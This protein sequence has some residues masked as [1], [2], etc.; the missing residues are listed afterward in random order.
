MS[1]NTALS[2]NQM[3]ARCQ[4]VRANK[5]LRRLPAWPNHRRR[6]IDS[7]IKELSMLDARKLG[8][9]F[10]WLESVAAKTEVT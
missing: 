3:H 2:H 1:Q 9:R 7:G 6:S 10:R 8:L 5:H 4:D